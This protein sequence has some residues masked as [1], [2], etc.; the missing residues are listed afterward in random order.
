MNSQQKKSKLY[1]TSFTV[2]IT[3]LFISSIIW[4]I[5]NEY[6]YVLDSAKDEAHSR[7]SIDIYKHRL[8]YLLEDVNRR[9][10]DYGIQSYWES[11]HPYVVPEPFTPEPCET[12]SLYDIEY[13]AAV[14]KQV[15][16]EA[17]TQP[18]L[19]HS[20]PQNGII[21]KIDETPMADDA[22]CILTYRQYK[23]MMSNISS[24]NQENT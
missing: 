8:V 9:V 12:Y 15:C 2:I 4:N 3:I 7:Y 16:E 6:R 18:E 17:Y 22:L 23:K 5:L 14:M 11:H 24:Q 20:A 19:I 21:S 13:W 10:I 1:F